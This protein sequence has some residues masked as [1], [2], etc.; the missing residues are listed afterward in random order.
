MI[1][2]TTLMSNLLL[3]I[4][5]LTLIALI[6]YVIKTWH[7]A[8]ATKESAKVSQDMLEEMKIA[9]DNESAPNIVVYF[10]MPAGNWL[11]YLIVK[12][13]GK[14]VANNVKL[15]FEPKLKTSRGENIN[16]IP[17][18][19]NGISSIP[20]SHEIKTIFDT[21]IDYINNDELPLNYS[22]KISYSGGIHDEVR[23]SEQILDLSVYKGLSFIDKKGMHELVKEIE[24]IGKN[25]K[26]ISSFLEKIYTNLSKGI[27]IKNPD[28][29][30]E[31]LQSEPD[32]WKSIILAKFKE[33]KELWSSVYDADQS[34]LINNFNTD[35]KIRG[36]IITK[37]ILTI[38]SKSPSNVSSET[39]T[40]II[41][42]AIY[43]SKLEQAQFYIER[44]V[45]IDNFD[46]TGNEIEKLINEIIK[47]LDTDL[48]VLDENIE[49][50]HLN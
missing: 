12:N 50:N 1:T 9:R 38:V 22:A 25:N 46:E 49:D 24:S 7:I 17:L 45:P 48:T 37:Q 42:V 41:D 35:L 16:D 39:V 23:L 43:L 6:V 5:T 3:G 27:W 31:I 26:K 11:I 18:I 20:P 30:I 4:Q 36:G 40:K 21:T 29:I 10:D 19:K 32:A 13:I 44:G 34:K 15:E 8:S 33:F 14:S 2:D 28:F 47:Q